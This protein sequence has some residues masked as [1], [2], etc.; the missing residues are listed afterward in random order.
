[1]EPQNVKIEEVRLVFADVSWQHFLP[2][3]SEHDPNLLSEDS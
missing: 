2:D 3:D 1:M